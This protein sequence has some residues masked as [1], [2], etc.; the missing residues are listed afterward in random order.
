[1]CMRDQNNRKSEREE[2]AWVRVMDRGDV[3]CLPVYFVIKP[4]QEQVQKVKKIMIRNNDN[5]I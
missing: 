5:Y 3:N 2:K 4:Q 1:M